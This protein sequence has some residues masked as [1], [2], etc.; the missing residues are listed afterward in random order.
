MEGSRSFSP[1]VF[2]RCG[3]LGRRQTGWR[4][5]HPFPVVALSLEGGSGWTGSVQDG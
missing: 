5:T 4:S 3:G 1:A 2:Q